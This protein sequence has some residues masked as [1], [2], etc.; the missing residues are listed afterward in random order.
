M[1][2]TNGGKNGKPVNKSAAIRDMMA[3][4]PAAQSKEIVA[5]LAEQGVKVQ[6]SLVY[7]IRSKQLHEKRRQR[8]QRVTEASVKTGTASPV[9]LILKVKGLARDAGGIQNLK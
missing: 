6:P 4:H 1:S 3:R 9:E 8:R 2:K 7:Y 5:F